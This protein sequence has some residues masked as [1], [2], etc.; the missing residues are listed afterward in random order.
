MNLDS[1]LLHLP[2]AS[3]CA[4][5][6]MVCLVSLQDDDYHMVG[7][8]AAGTRLSASYLAKVLQR[9]ARTGIIESRR[10][11]RGGYRL[12]RPADSVSLSE[13]ISASLGLEA[14]PMPCMIEAKDC[15][16]GRRCAMH[17]LVAS[18]EAA[19]WSRLEETTLASFME[20][21]QPDTRRQKERE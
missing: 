16:S 14:G 9:L 1:R 6:A 5:S 19:L 11:A 15:D 21:E 2:H 8:I 7:E 4:V 18:T 20:P 17:P 12:A 13:V 3:R 10:G